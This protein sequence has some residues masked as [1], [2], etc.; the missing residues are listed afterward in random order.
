[1]AG[2]ERSGLDAVDSELFAGVT[3]VLTPTVETDPAAYLEVR[4][5]VTSLGA[6]VVTLDADEHDHMVATVSHVPHLAASAI[7]AVAADHSD[8]H[9]V[10]LR[11]AAGGFRDMTRIAAGAPD[12]WT[13]I[14]IENR[15]AI[16]DCLGRLTATLDEVSEYLVG[17]NRPGLEKFLATA[18]EARRELP[19]R[20]GRPTELVSLAI[21]IPDRPGALG[22]VF[23]VFGEVKVNVE[24]VDINH[25]IQGGQGTLLLTV[26]ASGAGNATTALRRAGFSVTAEAL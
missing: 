21:V 24:D 4:S 8:A 15:E 26:A 13:D 16:L 25:A 22:E 5:V 19:L 7:M 11:L 10:L 23:T 2:S 17:A 12:L 1:M 18:A 9:A 6:D 14:V 3:W 20:Q